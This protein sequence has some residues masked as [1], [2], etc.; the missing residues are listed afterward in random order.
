MPQKENNNLKNQLSYLKK[1]M[2]GNDMSSYMFD[3]IQPQATEIEEAVLG[4]MMLDK[5]AV[6]N[7]I[8]ILKPESFYVEANQ[9]IYR[10]FQDLFLKNKPID[11]LTVS[12][13]LKKDGELENVGGAFYISQ[14][15]NRVGSSANVEHHARIVSEKYILRELIRTSSKVIKNAYDETVDVFELLDAT[16]QNLFEITDQ[17]LRRN[18][19]T[20]GN[21]LSIA[22]KQIEEISKNDVGVIGI[23]SGF[24]SLDKI[25]SGWQ[26]SDLVILAARPGMGKTS[27]TLS[28][29]RNAAVDH[30]KPVAFF[31]LE[32][33]SVQLV[34]RLIS[35]E[36]EL[37]GEKLKKG[38][39]ERYEWEQLHSKIRTLSDAQL[40]I[41]DTPGL[42]IFE[43]RAKCRRLK[44]QHD[45]QMVI[46]DYLQLMT[47]SGDKKGNR[48]Q[49]IS[50][51]SRSLKGIAKELDIPVIALSQLSRAVE[52]RG[53]NKKPQLS[54]LRE[55][56]A[57][58]Q[59]ADMV[60]FLYR[61]E[62]YGFDQ[63]DDGNPTQ[64][65]AEVIIAKHRNGALDTVKTRFISKFAK[66]AELDLMSGGNVD[67]YIP[68]SQVITKESKMN[69][70]EQ[71]P[72][73]PPPGY[74]DIPF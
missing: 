53:G 18:Y 36:A 49:E 33:S 44:M 63:D 47:G 56:G 7:V 32:M 20:M 54:D 10:A 55:S 22:I 6:S 69:G 1:N 28:L 60:I 66:F 58:E 3:K 23:P 50:Q 62:Y 5:D 19:D 74:D 26:K 42:N 41:D 31:S 29:A 12:E 51:I 15:A 30:K 65:V 13:Q 73:P 25:T 17:N 14:L 8:D 38:D 9:K 48:E 45:I 72:P 21:L 4:A 71:T 27:F 37:P 61:P 57:I 46:I 59:D 39:L 24:T 70:G 11:L 16:E 2:N 35:S 52:T 40:F 64:G 67:G 43:L 68:L 34:N